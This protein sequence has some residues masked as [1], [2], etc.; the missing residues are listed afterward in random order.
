M[1]PLE[2]AYEIVMSNA[3]RS[4]VEHA[5][6]TDSLNRV[7]AEDVFSDINMPPFDKSAFDGYAVRKEDLAQDLKVIEVIPAGK[8][9]EKSIKPGQ[10]S[11]IMT[12][13]MIPEG[14]D[15]VVKVEDTQLLG[16][17]NVRFTAQ[18]AASTN[19]CIKGEDI[20]EGDLVL[21]KGT[22]IRPQH[23]AVLA[24]VGKANPLVFSRPVV[25]VLSTGNELVEPS[26]VPSPSQIRNS[27]AYQLLA[28]L[29]KAG[30]VP[31][32]EGIALDTEVSLTKSIRNAF[33][34]YDILLLTGGVSMGDYDF[35]PKVMDN[36]GIKILFK[37]VAIQPG[38]PTVFGSRG[39]Q[40]IFGLPGNPVSA[41]VVFEM[42]VKPFLYKIMGASSLPEDIQLTMG[43]DFSRDKSERTTFFPVR[44]ADGQVFPLE[45][46]G[47]A[48]I[49]A[50]TM[51]DGIC[52]MEIGETLLVKGK[53]VNVR[54]L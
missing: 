1:I 32:Y 53:S 41:F 3:Q 40:F 13:A 25:G 23:I 49:N 26:H 24:S 30:A 10:C 7:L 12:G 5:G 39:N 52:R 20:N 9:P 35:V 34:Q 16:N 22:R 17:G 37:S 18:E 8:L 15:C 2:E 43:K 47:S 38:R 46:H 48:H 29:T 4:G 6:L 45:Y 36:L 21:L 31:R 51:A 11:K 19:I 44:I 28:Q 54:Q 14:A 27:N 33:D 50:Y 42:L